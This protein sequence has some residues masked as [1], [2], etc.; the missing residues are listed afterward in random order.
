MISEHA[1]AFVDNQTS[2]MQIIKKSQMNYTE[3]NP[4]LNSIVLFERN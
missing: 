2:I 3:Y 4:F 1:L